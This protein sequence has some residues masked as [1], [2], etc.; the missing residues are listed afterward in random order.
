LDRA[1]EDVIE[2]L[3]L[4]L[5]LSV[6]AVV[7]YYALRHAHMRR[8]QPAVGSAGLPALLYFKGDSCAAC[9]AQGRVVDQLAA[10]WADRLR[11]ERIDAERNPETAAGYSVFTL[12]T[13]ILVGGDGRVRHVNYGLTDARKL[14]RQLE[15]L[16]TVEAAL[17]GRQ[18][19]APAS[20][21]GS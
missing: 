4:V 11:V 3:A 10:Q 15:S 18:S 20:T 8:I 17:D 16:T 19:V 5:A 2:R 12:P 14:A 13:T 21:Q 7:A 1:G 9:P 6:V